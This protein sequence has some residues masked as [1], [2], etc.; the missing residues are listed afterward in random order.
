MCDCAKEMDNKLKDHNGRLAMAIL[1][2]AAGSN[3]LRARLLVQTEKLDKMKRKPVPSVMA[4][5]CPFCGESLQLADAANTQ[6][7]PCGEA[8]SA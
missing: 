1:M 4:S 3:C 8:T 7:K 5:Y 6:A 2:P